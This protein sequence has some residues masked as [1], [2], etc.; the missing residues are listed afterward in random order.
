MAISVGAC[1]IDDKAEEEPAAAIPHSPVE[2]DGVVYTPMSVGPGGC[3]LYNVQI[4]GGYAPA[5]MAYQSVDGQFSF[6]R[7]T[8]CVK[9]GAIE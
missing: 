3:L 8:Q 2:R 4:P 6:G 5:A 9:A 7:P 1:T